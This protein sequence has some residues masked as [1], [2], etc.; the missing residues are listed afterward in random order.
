MINFT[1]RDHCTDHVWIYADQVKM[2]EDDGIHAIITMIDG[3]KIKTWENAQEIVC[4]IE[5][6]RKRYNPDKRLEA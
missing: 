6:A 5:A 4:R 2:V 3:S 1:K